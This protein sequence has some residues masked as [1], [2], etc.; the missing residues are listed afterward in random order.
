MFGR[1]EKKVYLL[2]W[3]MTESLSLI[4]LEGGR[5]ELLGRFPLG[6]RL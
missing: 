1:R 2:S 3:G 6:G 5:R 4:V